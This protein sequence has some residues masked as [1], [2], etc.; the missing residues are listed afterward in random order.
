MIKLL[1]R[2]RY[3]MLNRRLEAELAEEI[4]A[5]R[6]MLEDR[7]GAAASR[8]AMGNVMLAREDAR[9]MWLGS[10]LESVWQD[11]VYAV[12]II[13]RKPAF[14]ASMIVVMSLG[15]GATTG[16]FGLI[17]GLVVRSLPVR[18]PDRLVYLSQPAFSYPVFSELRRRGPH[19]FSQLSAWSLT[20]ENIEWTTE[21]EPADVLMATGEFHSML[22]IGASVG[23]TFTEQDDQIGGGPSGLVA[24]IS[25]ACWQRRFGGD[26]TV[27][28]RTVR[29]K[30]RPFTIIGVTPPGFFGV[31][32]GQAPEITV[33]LTALSDEKTV[34]ATTSSWLHL[35]G[36]MNDGLTRERANAALQGI[37]PAVL[38]VTTNPGMPADRRAMYLG[39]TTSL[40]S[41]RAGYSRVRNQFE[42]PLWL[43]LALV[44]LLLTVAT[45]SAANLLLARGVA[46][47]RELAVRL[48]IGAGRARLVRQML[49]EALVWTIFGAA[50]GLLVASWG[51]N[52]LVAMMTTW[53]EPIALE[54]GP[55]WRVVVFTLTLAFFTAAVCAVVPALRTTRLNPGST[56][57]EFGQIGGDAGRRWSLGKSLVAA[58]IALTVLLLFGAALFVRSLQRILGQDAGFERN[59]VLVVSTDAMAAGYS[60]ERLV[61][62]YAGLLD[63]LR[64]I[65]GVESAS[66]SWYPPI[67]DQDGAW[68]Q[69]IG[70][71]G[72]AVQSDVT[73]YVYFNAVTPGYFRTLGIRLLR[74]RDF[75]GTDRA[76]SAR[77]A[78]ITE[79][80]ARRFFPDVNPVGRRVSIGR[81]ASR[82]DLE[83]VGVVSDAK[84][85]RLQ[86]S[87]RSIAYLPAAQLPEF[88][89]GENLVAEVRAAGAVMPVAENVRREVRAL[90]GAVPV[91]IQTITDR[92]RASLVTERVVATLAIG[93]GLAALALACTGL[94]GLL[95][96]TVSRQTNEIGLRLALGAT[97]AGMLR[98]VLR[99]SLVLGAVGIAAGLAASVALGR[100]AR[101]LL[102][103]VTATDPLALAVAGLVM[104]AVAL[105]AGFFPARRAARIDPVVALRTS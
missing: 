54:T 1:R 96:Y 60:G 89:A 104:L 27:I 82:R 11:A 52:A 5:H 45:A 68:T 92:I 4:E 55:N 12:R 74:G 32:P 49:T 28:G 2:I 41:G 75:A 42:E 10:W 85:Q 88:M 64:A 33:P 78:I 59:A 9:R 72:A 83:I 47:R 99:Q 40:E 13:R 16:V 86:E 14:A 94:Y 58:Q 63:R 65:P 103:Q 18:D 67:S 46:R 31:A 25:H 50:A 39:R 66:M 80:L 73:R 30:R 29:I 48:A 26:A 61:A 22:G 84:Y 7:V 62:F 81:N 21:L 102:F 6:A 56:L 98:M 97:R 70:I 24:V 15:I 93:L 43:L 51:G 34:R 57:K 3:A 38:E 77:V 19:I 101:N 87:T 91:R 105:A 90:D 35:L 44:G 100:F 17:D 79:S 95:A 37:W 76:D 36:R 71:D 8:R 23:R 69:S 20:R 53:E